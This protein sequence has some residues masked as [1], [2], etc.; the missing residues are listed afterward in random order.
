MDLKR[1]SL[2]HI[3]PSYL[4]ALRK[5]LHPRGRY[6]LL[7]RQVLCEIQAEEEH[8]ERKEAAARARKREEE[9]G[10]PIRR[11]STLTGERDRRRR[12][13]KWGERWYLRLLWCS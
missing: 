1:L 5:I 9:R 10:E 4:R 13:N 8:S 3:P 12:L 7:A 2:T 6:R 11:S